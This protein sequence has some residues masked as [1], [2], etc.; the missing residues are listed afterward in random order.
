VNSE[1]LVQLLIAV[2]G[3]IGTGGVIN[4]WANRRKVR[5]DTTEVVERASSGII[6]RLEKEVD[7]LDRKLT[8][9]SEDLEKE[10]LDRR[11]EAEQT[12][13]RILI[14]E[15]G[16]RAAELRAEKLSNDLVDVARMLVD[17]AN[18]VAAGE[19]LTRHH[20]GAAT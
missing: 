18:R 6:E 14:A 7:R 12:N 8:R 4:A 19:I 17:E 15:D 2:I 20:G 11:A 1:T 16:R 10:R 3:V 13:A 5:A 9:V